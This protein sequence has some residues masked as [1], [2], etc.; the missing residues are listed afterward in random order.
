MRLLLILSTCCFLPAAVAERTILVLADSLSASYGIA[1]EDGWVTLL[2][3]R[4]HLQGYNYRVI[5]ASISGDTTAGA[6]ARLDPLLSHEQPDIAVIE[7]G[8][9]DGLRGLSIMEIKKNLVRII[10][11]LLQKNIRVLLIP[12]QI[13]PNYGQIYTTKFR[14]IYTELAAEYG[15]TLSRFILDNIVLEQPELIQED[16]IHPK[17]EAQPMM[18]DNIWFDLQ[19]MLKKNDEAHEILQ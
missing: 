3:D 2:Q 13:P 8:G 9:N 18:L 15:I 6:S 17:A 7:L 12:M 14:E 5:N 1:V 19:P 4:L 11:Q 16:G 10:R